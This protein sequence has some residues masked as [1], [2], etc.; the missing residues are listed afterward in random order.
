MTQRY[1]QF[2]FYGKESGKSYPTTFCVWFF[3]KSISCYIR[4]TSLISFPDCLYLLRHWAICVLQLFVNQVVT[5]WILKLTC[6][7]NRAISNLK[8]LPITESN[9][10]QWQ[11]IISFYDINYIIMILV[12]NGGSCEHCV[13]LNRKSWLT[14]WNFCRFSMT[15]T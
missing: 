3:T 4:L 2:W 12:K 10:Y 7:S 8:I 6:L 13:S 15:I 11:S 5:P 9:F 1:A 14:H